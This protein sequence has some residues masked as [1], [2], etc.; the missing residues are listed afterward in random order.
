MSK[1]GKIQSARHIN[2]RLRE[3][4]VL[5]HVV[6]AKRVPVSMLVSFR[7]DRRVPL[8]NVFDYVIQRKFDSLCK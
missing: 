2:M 3:I 1:P 5:W 4:K 8:K 6:N 7:R